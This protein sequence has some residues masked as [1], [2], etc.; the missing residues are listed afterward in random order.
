MKKALILAI[1]MLFS[2]AS[3]ILAFQP[4]E[5]MGYSTVKTADALIH[6][7]AGFFYGFAC[8]TDGTNSVTF[9]IYDNTEASGTKLAPSMICTTSASNRVCV[10]GTGLGVPFNTGLYIDITSSDATPDYVI[11]Y[12]GK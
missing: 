6:T 4:Q 12:R 1:V 8:L 2:F 11:Y 5:W 3:N 10:F 7:G 9:D